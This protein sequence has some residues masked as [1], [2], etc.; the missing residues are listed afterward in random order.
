MESPDEGLEERIRKLEERIKELEERDNGQSS[1][2]PPSSRQIASTSA[3]TQR[4]TSSTRS[5]DDGRPK[6]SLTGRCKLF[7]T[8]EELDHQIEIPL[9][10]FRVSSKFSRYFID[11]GSR[12]LAN[13]I[14][15][16]APILR[17]F[18]GTKADEI[19]TVAASE[20]FKAGCKASGVAD[21]TSPA[22]TERANRAYFQLLQLS[23][24]LLRGEVSV[25]LI[26]EQLVK[27]TSTFIR[28]KR[29]FAFVSAPRGADKKSLL[30]VIIARVS[31]PEWTQSD[32][33]DPF[34][35]LDLAKIAMSCSGVDKRIESMVKGHPSEDET[36]R[37][38]AAREALGELFRKYIED[39][40]PDRW[41]KLFG[42]VEDLAYQLV[43]MF[44]EDVGKALGEFAYNAEHEEENPR[45]LRKKEELEILKHLYSEA[46]EL[47]GTGLVNQEALKDPDWLEDPQKLVNVVSDKRK[48]L[49]S[50]EMRLIGRITEEFM[51]LFIK[52]NKM[53]LTP[54][55][56][57]A[58][59]ILMFSQFYRLSRPNASPWSSKCKALILQM[60]TGEGKS[61][62]IAF[63]AVFL[64]LHYKD[65]CKQIHILTNN[66]ALLKR[67]F[68]A[69]KPF[70]ERFKVESGYS[71]DV[72][73]SD[74]IDT[75]SSIC[76]TLKKGINRFF[77][78]NIVNG[79]LGL[80]GIILL[81]R[82]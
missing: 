50:E 58:L 48:Q 62:V 80:E 32:L 41:V 13:S 23:V 73:C 46:K 53:P 45:N 30:A 78:R 8:A 12:L 20:D 68:A 34:E 61:I 59:A 35:P 79:G 36:K 82:S 7:P 64:Y 39:E 28:E 14:F 11:E 27:V 71:R 24:E 72:T 18:H 29:A 10:S 26:A 37:Q 66:D 47:Y 56:T 77:N 57:Q 70:C 49:K 21:L 4:K 63:L 15:W 9:R 60:K 74:E 67:D 33:D 38:S 51:K 16:T 31:S 25:Q 43:Y 65:T 3:Q 2:A 69:F 17:L 75:H 6:S 19:E 1:A 40:R 42:N 55:H 22:L 54:H 76:F 44:R 81:V 5:L 52:Q